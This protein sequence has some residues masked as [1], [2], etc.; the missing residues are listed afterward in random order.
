MIEIPRVVWA[1]IKAPYPPEL[2]EIIYRPPDYETF[3]KHIF[4]N[5]PP[6]ILAGEIYR[7]LLDLRSHTETPSGRILGDVFRYFTAFPDQHRVKLPQYLFPVDECREFINKMMACSREARRPMTVPEQLSLALSS[8]KGNV[9]RAIIVLSTATRAAARNYEKRL[10]VK[11]SPEEMEEW[12]TCVAPFDY[13]DGIGDPP[14]DTYHFWSAVLAGMSTEI[15]TSDHRPISEKAIAT[16]LGK[17]YDNTAKLT[18]LLRHRLMGHPGSSH[19]T[20]DIL[21]LAIGRA[22]C[23]WADGSDQK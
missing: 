9:L 22:L 4:Y 5:P 15:I 10:G 12:K 14:G 19:E 23:Y 1:G 6:E 3:E 8:V 21:G 2:Q 7:T 20:A 13:Q 18:T 11:V 16:I 17:A